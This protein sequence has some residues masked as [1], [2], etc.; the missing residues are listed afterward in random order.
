M[1]YKKSPNQIV[2]ELRRKRRGQINVK[3]KVN[4]TPSEN[5]VN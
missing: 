4:K 3:I 1:K 2:Q 5:N